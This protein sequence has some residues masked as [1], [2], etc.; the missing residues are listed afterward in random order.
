MVFATVASFVVGFL[1]FS[2]Q[3]VEEIVETI[4]TNLQER[5]YG[6]YCQPDRRWPTCAGARR[7][8]GE[9]EEVRFTGAASHRVARRAAGHERHCGLCPCHSSATSRYASSTVSSRY[10]A[11][12]SERVC[13]GGKVGSTGFSATALIEHIADLLFRHV[14]KEG[15][16]RSKHIALER[17][18][19]LFC[20][21][22]MDVHVRKF[23]DVSLFVQVLEE[24]VEVV[25]LLAFFHNDDHH[26]GACDT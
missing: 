23:V 4:Q 12:V 19:Q 6:M 20:Q 26:E 2:P 13:R 21:Q 7:G 22:F 10:S 18:L 24:Y 3:L 25:T 17:C 16:F 9:G 15:V 5:I 1:T 14:V 8:E 11:S